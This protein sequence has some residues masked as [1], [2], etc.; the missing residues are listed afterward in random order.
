M[1]RLASDFRQVSDGIQVWF[2]GIMYFRC[3]LIVIFDDVKINDLIDLQIQVKPDD[4]D[5]GKLKTTV[6]RAT[7]ST[8]MATELTGRSKN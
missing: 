5:P 3:N 6:A 2:A 4:H 7:Q 1:T 8:V